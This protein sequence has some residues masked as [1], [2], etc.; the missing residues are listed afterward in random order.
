MAELYDAM[1]LRKGAGILDLCCG[2]GALVSSL[3]R[4]TEQAT[5]L[6]V[7]QSGALVEEARSFARQ[8]EVAD[9]VRFEVAEVRSWSPP[10][11]GFDV[12]ACIGARPWGSRH[13]CLAA[14]AARARP[15][16]FVLYG[17]LYWRHPPD[18]AYLEVLGCQASEQ[19]ELAR[20][21]DPGE[22][23]LDLQWWATTTPQQHD[24]YERRYLGN[25]LAHAR[26]Q[27]GDPTALALAQ[28]ARRWR[29]AHLRWGR[30]TLGFV[31]GAW[32]VN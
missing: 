29:D 16:G 4:R 2:K 23:P 26:S 7:D 8:E 9:R 22:L 18:A 1:A 21:L 14:L 13:D 27:P 31:V 30:D 10:Q 17:D 12:V 24:E 11:P 6:G 28:G 20:T 3:V 25:L 5:G 19:D 32:R 15:G